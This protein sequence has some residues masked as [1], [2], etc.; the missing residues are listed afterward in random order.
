MSRKYFT[1]YAV[2]LVKDDD[3]KYEAKIETAYDAY[4]KILEVFRLDKKAEEYCVMFCLDSKNNAIGAFLISKGSVNLT[5]INVTDIIKRAILC[6]SKRIIIAHNHPSGS[7]E[8]SRHDIIAT[9]KINDACNLMGIDFLD[10]LI[11]GDKQFKSIIE[12]K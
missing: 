6:N 9:K 8:P 4:R 11:I 3:F 12:Q 7:T 2:E 1:K 10:H 5:S